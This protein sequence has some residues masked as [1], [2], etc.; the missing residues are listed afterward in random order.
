MLMKPVF[1]PKTDREV[2]TEGGGRLAAGGLCRQ[3]FPP[4]A[5]TSQR[6]TPH[7]PSCRLHQTIAERAL[8]E[9]EEERQVEE[10]EK[11]LEERKEETRLLLQQRL[12]LEA[13]QA[14]AE[15]GGPKGL[16]DINT[17][18]RGAGGGG[19]RTRLVG[20]WAEVAASGSTNATL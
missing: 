13:A 4:A 14:A 16:D 19:R 7:A 6:P 8:L 15:R 5:T 17:G 11:R 2:G 1:V 18:G 20:A 10:K 9:A 3:A 12:E